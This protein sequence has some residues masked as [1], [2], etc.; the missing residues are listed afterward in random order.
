[1]I[2]VMPTIG[3]RQLRKLH[4]RYPVRS[5][6]SWWQKLWIV[7]VGS[8]LA[9][10]YLLM[11]ARYKVPGLQFRVYCAQLALHLFLKK[12]GNVSYQTIFSLLFWPFDSTRYFEFDFIWRRI[13]NF[14]P[15]R[16][17]DVSSPRLFPLVVMRRRV[18]LT[19]EILNPDSNDLTETRNLARA[20]GIENRCN[21]HNVFVESAPFDP[22]SFDLI[23]CISVLEHIPHNAAALRTMWDLLRPG[24]RLYLTLPCLA[25]AAV[26]Y[27]NMNLYGL[28]VPR[29]E[30]FTF[31]QY[32][33]DEAL[34]REVVF[35][36]TGEPR[37]IAI[38]GEKR[39]GLFR[40]YVDTARSNPLYPRWR[41]PYR[42]GR[43]F[44]EFASIPAL[45]G[46]G[47]V[48]MEFVKP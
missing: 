19:A 12:S 5:E 23:T 34:L 22:A 26:Q 14:S 9:P 36:I 31:L 25:E 10:A 8:S 27:A 38:Y 13:S 44:S 6:R 4:I 17:L 39:E 20:T 46:E 48:A 11:A 37:S 42:M 45:P 2:D 28:R 29:E 16:Y 7:F 18:Q 15:G 40:R 1:M 47:V 41:D 33:Y 35:P 43:E 3:T 21:F 32:Y 24:G 30:E